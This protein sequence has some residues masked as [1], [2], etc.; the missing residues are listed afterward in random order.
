MIKSINSSSPY[1]EVQ[2]GTPGSIYVNLSSTNPG[3]GTVRFN[4]QDMEVYDGS[5][6]QRVVN[7]YASVGLNQQAIEILNWAG[8]KMMEEAKLEELAKD[9]PTIADALS[10]YKE[11]EEQLK[12]ILTLTDKA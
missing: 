2:G 7:S 6:W 1:L 8:K 11:A 3:T 12:V 5:M 10:K 4:G 9:N